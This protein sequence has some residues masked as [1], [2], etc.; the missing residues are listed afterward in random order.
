[1]LKWDRN[2]LALPFKLVFLAEFLY[3][4]NAFSVYFS[5]KTNA[6]FT[7]SSKINFDRQ[8]SIIII[9]SSF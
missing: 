1:M 9:K 5:N 8:T 2:C 3:G 6:R 4:T 7:H